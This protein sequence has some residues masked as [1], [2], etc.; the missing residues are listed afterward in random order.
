M[1]SFI[2]PAFWL[3]TVAA[4]FHASSASAFQRVEMK[5]PDGRVGFNIV[6]EDSRLFYEVKFMDA[7]VIEKSPLGIV[8]DGV[9]LGMSVAIGKVERYSL[10]ESYPWRGVHPIAVNHCVGERVSLKQAK[11]DR[12]YSLEAVRL[13]TA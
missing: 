11:T 10:N 6:L 2:K 9:D 3:A 13:T 4:V 1:S 8:V 7:P 5:G 12:D